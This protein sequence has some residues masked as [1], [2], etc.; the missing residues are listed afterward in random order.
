MHVSVTKFS[1]T[2]T[3]LLLLVVC[4]KK[5]ETQAGFAV[6]FIPRCTPIFLAKCS[7]ANGSRSS[8]SHR[9]EI[10]GAQQLERII[11]VNSTRNRH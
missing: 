11:I 9:E 5:S 7:I 10:E 8:K 6:T 3:V 2:S 1:D 4:R